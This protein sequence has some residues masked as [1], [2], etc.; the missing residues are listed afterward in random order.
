MLVG[1]V[2]GVVTAYLWQDS[3][4]T[5]GL[6]RVVPAQVSQRIVESSVSD[7]LAMKLAPIYQTVTQRT[8]L[9][10][11]IQTYNLYPD[12]RRKYPIEDVVETMRRD[13]KMGS[14]RT[15]AALN[16]GSRTSGFAFT[17]EYTYHD[18][19]LV[20]KVCSDL[21]SS[22]MNESVR[23]RSTQFTQT[24]EF[25]REQL[26]QSRKELKEI[27]NRI[28]EF[29]TKN[30]GESPEQEQALNLRITTLEQTTSN[31]NN[32]V[33][34][35]QQ[36][37][38]QLEASL[39]TLQDQWAAM[40]APVVVEPQTQQ[41]RN[42]KLSALDKEISQAQEYLTNLKERYREDH[43]DVQRAQSFLNARLKEREQLQNEV[44]SVKPEQTRPRVY[45][46]NLNTPE[47]RRLQADISRVRSLIQSKDLELEDISRQLKEAREKIRGYMAQLES[48]PAAQQQYQELVRERELSQK[49]Y[50]DLVAKF[51]V[52][53]RA[54]EL[55]SRKQGETLEVLD[56]P[57]IPLE[58]SK[59]KRPL[60]I[61]GGAFGGILIGMLLAG[62]RE[63]KDTSLKNLKDVRAY[64]KLAVLAS[65]PL[66]EN[67][68]VVRRRRRLAWL[69][70]GAALLASVLMMAG[71]VAYYYL[72]TS[73]G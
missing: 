67:D 6:I 69:G 31:L 8:N 63:M 18:R 37:K 70:W 34:R 60:I 32:N 43:P 64:T 52:T 68:L 71:S 54:S 16:P 45:Q 36:E 53:E 73:R 23:L 26:D 39:R 22:F 4:V 14:V 59:P 27:D 17:L 55:E 7:E 72:Y 30:F 49:R 65:V 12:D 47:A 5:S 29:R 2:A 15:I 13:I 11:L 28:M 50:T 61:A 20:E 10:N 21:I 41:A 9:I 3:Y 25:V 66:L 19:R 42:E 58:P 46:P 35:V 56:R 38:L 48:S 24:N 57:I 44:A 33:S 40:Q 1:L 51:D 62:V